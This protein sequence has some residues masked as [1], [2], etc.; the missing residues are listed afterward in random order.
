[1]IAAAVFIVACE[2]AARDET[3][4][5]TTASTTTAGA[6]TS[7]AL[8]TARD[9]FI[10]FADT[11]EKEITDTSAYIMDT[12]TNN[13]T[14][15]V[16][17]LAY[18]KGDSVW[19]AVDTIFQSAADLLIYKDAQGRVTRARYRSPHEPGYE[20]TTYDYHFGDTG[21]TSDFE[22]SWSDQSN[23]C[24]ESASIMRRA[25][26]SDRG[27]VTGFERRIVNQDGYDMDAAKCFLGKYDVD[28]I[29]T[30]WAAFRSAIKAP[31]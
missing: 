26:L 22:R 18:S 19:E 7:R 5:T 10:V 9:T 12:S 13:G 27:V 2:Q 21:Y 23:G 24:A 15:R 3:A 16:R 29:Y 20:F 4:S 6:D 17:V 31:K 28:T 1:M 8:L 25:H 11:I 30:S 14:G